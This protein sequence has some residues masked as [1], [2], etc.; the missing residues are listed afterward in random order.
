MLSIVDGQPADP[1]EREQIYSQIVQVY[2]A[3][4]ALLLTA[5]VTLDYL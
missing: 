3:G 2:N 4:P 1:S 5:C